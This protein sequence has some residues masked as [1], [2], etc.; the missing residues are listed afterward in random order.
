MLN[1]EGAMEDR[2]ILLGGVEIEPDASKSGNGLQVLA[3]DVCLIVPDEA[4]PQGGPIAKKSQT[5]KQGA[6]APTPHANGEECT[7]ESHAVRFIRR[8]VPRSIS[9]QRQPRPTYRIVS[10]AQTGFHRM[11]P[12]QNSTPVFRSFPL[13]MSCSRSR[14]LQQVS[15]ARLVFLVHRR[16]EC[17][18]RHAFSHGGKTAR[19]LTAA[20]LG[21][22]LGGILCWVTVAAPWISAGLK[23][24][25]TAAP[26]PVPYATYIYDISAGLPH[27]AAWPVLQ[28][29]DGYLWIGTAAGLA[30]FDGVRFVTYRADNTP[31]LADNQI[32]C[33]LQ[34]EAGA[35]WVG[36]QRGLSRYWQGKMELIGLS[37]TA[38]TSVLR[39]RTGKLWIGTLEKG[40]W[41]YGEGR[42]AEHK[43]PTIPEVAPLHDVRS[44]FMDST[45]RV[46]MWLRSK[47][48]AYFEGDSLHLFNGFGATSDQGVPMA[49]TPSGTLWFGTEQGV[50]RL[51]D[52]QLRKYGKE[53]GLGT[54]AV[55][56]LFADRK[57][58]LW[59]AANKLYVLEQP[60]AESFAAVPIAVE[61]ARWVMQDR[62]GS[63]WVGTAN[64][65]LWQFRSSAYRMLLPQSTLLEGNVRAVAIERA[66]ATWASLPDGGIARIAPEGK[67]SVVE[68]DGV[69]SSL[70]PADD[71]SVWIGTKIGRA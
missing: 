7:L 39:D 36:T 66:G 24:G 30:R 33:L 23:A 15:I 32:R 57:G 63:Y 52:G 29:R 67:A 4:P 35:L 22:A 31:G 61:Y 5:Q 2:I 37:G 14:K 46:W 44:L 47:G 69:V 71:G 55:R 70:C 21:R 48:M 27:N 45:G 28:T 25:E 26:P 10:E 11:L 1:P 34:D 16:A 42:L 18:V 17:Q 64:E 54:A 41:E 65:G 19:S 8:N 68:T 51:R 58:Q 3:S 6:E 43:D 13:T 62:E 12:S 59:V 38:I 50:F 60:E 40:L 49:E 53:Q 56:N 20:T 9:I